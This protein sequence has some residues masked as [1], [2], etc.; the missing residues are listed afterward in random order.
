MPLSGCLQ[1]DLTQSHSM[2]LLPSCFEDVLKDINLK[3]DRK[4]D[5]LTEL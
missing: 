3:Q 2:F 5:K 4:Q 1:K